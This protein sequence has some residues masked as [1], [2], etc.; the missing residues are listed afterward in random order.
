MLQNSP[1]NY[2]QQIY[3]KE[4]TMKIA[5]DL[6]GSNIRV[7]QVVNGVVC[8]KNSIPC[9][10]RESETEVLSQLESLIAEMITDEVTG[11]G[12]GVPSVVNTELGIVYNV[13]NI[14]S[15]KEVH[16]KQILQDKFHV[17]VYVNNDSNCFALGEKIFGKGK[18]FTNIV[19]VTLGTGVGSGVIINDNLYEGSNAGAGEI[20]TLPYLFHNFE[21]YCSSTF[22][23]KYHNCSGKDAYTRAMAGDVSAME[24][25]NE[26]GTHL[27]HLINAILYTYDPDAII[28]GGSIANAFLFFE[29]AM[30]EII[31]TF[32]YKE[33]IEKIQILISQDPD[34]SIL[35]A[36]ALIK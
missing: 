15:W 28:L 33:V 21:H 35:G 19:G 34:I 31:Y 17:P 29:K 5:I 12:I 13:T 4:N 16:L 24:I 20:G 8:K 23:Q 3:K 27:G 36:S 18:S 7:G 10:S 14:P 11:I 30:N 1:Y 26:F 32:P 25:W 22:F 2:N 9:P 6:G